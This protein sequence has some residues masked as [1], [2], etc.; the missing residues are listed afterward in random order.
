MEKRTG[1]KDERD[2]EGVEEGEGKWKERNKEGDSERGL[3]R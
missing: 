1:D 3:G 2:R